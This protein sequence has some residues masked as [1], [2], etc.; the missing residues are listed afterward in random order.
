MRHDDGEE[1]GF[2]YLPVLFSS[3]YYTS[4]AQ[5]WNRILLPQPLPTCS[6]QGIEV[7]KI[8]NWNVASEDIFYHKYTASIKIMRVLL[9]SPKFTVNDP[10]LY[11]LSQLHWWTRGKHE[12]FTW[13]PFFHFS[14]LPLVLLYPVFPSA[15]CAPRSET[16]S[17]SCAFW[18]LFSLWPQSSLSDCLLPLPLTL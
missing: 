11:P 3:S 8:H 7:S 1:R 10:F 9:F 5:T 16:D 15:Q 13:A 6:K 18:Q 4:V 12:K 2:Y 17:I 14:F